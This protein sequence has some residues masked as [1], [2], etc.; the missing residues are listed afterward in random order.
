MF[1]NKLHF[2][3]CELSVHK[4]L[5]YGVF[6]FLLLF[7]K[8]PWTQRLP[9]TFCMRQILNIFIYSIIYVQNLFLE[10]VFFLFNLFKCS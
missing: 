1:G 6:A 2:F 3:F 5:F 10:P 4:I 7:L 9:F 8:S